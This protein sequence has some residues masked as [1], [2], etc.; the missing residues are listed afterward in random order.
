MSRQREHRKAK[1]REK[2]RKKRTAAQQRR[3][4]RKVLGMTADRIEQ[5]RNWP[6][7]TCW[8]SDNWHEQGAQVVVAFCRRHDDGRMAAAYFELDLAERGVV[9]VHADAP[10][11]EVQV[12]T[13]LAKHSSEER[14]LLEVDPMLAVK[15]VHT[16][17]DWGV[18]QGHDQPSGL[19]R[20][21]R[22][23]GG[24]RGSKAREE[25]RTGVPDP[26]APPPQPTSDGM[27]ASLKRRLFG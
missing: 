26:N 23:F 6:M 2:V 21:A 18:K 10:L 1:K 15:L 22:I 3:G 25:I 13:E 17:R 27:F 14:P 8:A 4:T 16:A 7:A 12:H 24:V 20:A 9:S 11:T 5:T 19:Q